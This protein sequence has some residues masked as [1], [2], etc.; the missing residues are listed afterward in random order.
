MNPEKSTSPEKFSAWIGIDWADQKH[1]YSIWSP[2]QG[3]ERGFFDQSPEAIDLWAKSLQQRFGDGPVAIILEQKR[4]PLLSALAGY[5]FLKIFP[6]NPV[7]AAK[8]RQAMYPSGAKSDPVDSDL[9]LEILRLHAGRLRPLFWADEQTRLLAALTEDRRH[10]VDQ[11]TALIEE[12]TAVLK[13]CFPVALEVAGIFTSG[14]GPAFLLKWPTLADAQKARP[15]ALRQ[16]FY[17]QNARARIEERIARLKAAQPLTQDTAIVEAGRRRVV[18]LARLIVTLNL[19]I[20][21]YDQRIAE[22]FARHPDA[23]IFDS[24]PAGKIIKPRVLAAFGLDRS[25][26]HSAA[27][28]Q[29]YSGL[30][31]VQKSSGKALSVKARSACPKHLKQTFHEYAG[32]TLLYDGWAKAYYQWKRAQG[33]AHQAAVRSL[34]FKWQRVIFA[35]WKYSQPYDEAAHQK[36]LRSK[37]VPYLHLIAA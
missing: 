19:G 28:L 22:V 13:G 2:S 3:L 35:C 5:S 17:G 33:K 1:A 15:H 18:V 4:G 26:Y 37:N 16:F 30:A 23:E 20:K 21:E 29:C 7:T 8:F 27:E 12:L 9:L 10:Y 34:G 32:V 36:K 24:L 31:P 25:R 6:V 14:V 11:R